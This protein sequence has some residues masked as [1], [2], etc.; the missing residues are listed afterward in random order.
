LM[1]YFE[2]GSSYSHATKNRWSPW[3]GGPEPPDPPWSVPLRE[4]RGGITFYSIARQ[5]YIILFQ[6]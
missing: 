4:V 6:K 2:I 1:N 3:A 5:F